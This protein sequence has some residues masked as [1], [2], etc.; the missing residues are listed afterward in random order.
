MI[1]KVM[2]EDKPTLLSNVG[3]IY[4]SHVRVSDKDAKY[5]PYKIYLDDTEIDNEK[6]KFKSIPLDDFSYSNYVRYLKNQKGLLKGLKS[7]S[8]KQLNEFKMYVA[9]LYGCHIIPQ[10]DELIK[11]NCGNKITV[12]TY[13]ID[14]VY[15]KDKLRYTP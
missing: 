3:H 1:Y 14:L 11:S 15:Y 9:N 13:L 7:N 5:E 2:K 8:E 6:E 12:K 4:E 10:D